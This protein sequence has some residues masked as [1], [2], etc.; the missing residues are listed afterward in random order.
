MRLQLSSVIGFVSALTLGLSVEA[1]G[2]G[3]DLTVTMSQPS[4]TNVYQTARYTVTVANTGNQTSN[5]GSL[6]IQLPRTH[7]SPT[8]YVLGTVNGMITT[9][10]VVTDKGTSDAQQL[11]G[12]PGPALQRAVHHPLHEGQLPPRMAGD[13]GVRPTAL[14]ASRAK[15]TGRMSSRSQ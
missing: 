2:S 14:M 13:C 3:P 12:F 1:A 7:T 10:S 8:V 4:G 5:A 9:F 15:S 11:A 6:S